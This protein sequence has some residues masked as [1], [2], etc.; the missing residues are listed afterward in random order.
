ML[1]GQLFENIEDP[2]GNRPSKWHMVKDE[3][4][5]SLGGRRCIATEDGV[6]ELNAALSDS[7]GKLP[8]RGILS[9]RMCIVARTQ[10]AKHSSGW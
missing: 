3:V 7:K 1:D 8:K 2:E 9:R 5:Q 6:L 4:D 10:W